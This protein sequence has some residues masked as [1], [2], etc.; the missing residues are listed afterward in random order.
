MQPLFLFFKNMFHEQKNAKNMFLKLLTEQVFCD[1]LY[2]NKS[3]GNIYAKII[4][5]EGYL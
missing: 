4:R 3:F 5:T 1:I 2:P